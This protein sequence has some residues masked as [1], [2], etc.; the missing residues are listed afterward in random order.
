MPPL[1]ETKV[2][3]LKEAARQLRIEVLR[4]LHRAKSGHTGGSLSIIEIL[5]ALYLVKLRHDPQNP[6]WAERD[7]FILSKGHG[8]PALYAILARLGYFDAAELLNLRK[9]GGMLQGHPF[10]LTTPGVEISTG[11]LG[12]GLSVANGMALAARLDKSPVRIYALMGDGE[13]QE[14]QV[15][16]AAMTAA[17]YKLDNVCGIIDANKLQIDGCLCQIKNIEPLAGKW[18]SF[19]WQVFEVDGHDVQDLIS[20]FDHCEQVKGKPSVVI[21]HTIKGKGVS[22]MEGKVQYHGV[23]PTEEEL[24]KAL[25]ELR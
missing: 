4:M 2:L 3:E 1:P 14:G 25:E 17:H 5:V 18:E 20:A 22:F 24:E 6:R 11:S 15:W 19:G 10:N 7:R 13:I 8:A 9:F 23:A 12:Q 16:E 21:A